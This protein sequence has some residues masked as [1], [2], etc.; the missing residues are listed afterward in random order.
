VDLRIPIKVQNGDRI[1]SHGMGHEG[2]GVGMVAGGLVGLAAVTASAVDSAA[3][4]A[5]AVSTVSRWSKALDAQR[6]RAAK[7][8]RALARTLI[9]NQALRK[10]LKD[11]ERELDI[12]RNC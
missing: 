8:E 10:K 3:Q 1:M 7:A 4:H 12:L 2:F 9:D 6:Q 5:R 11:V